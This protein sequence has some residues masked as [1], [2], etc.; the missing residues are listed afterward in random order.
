M[1]G[2]LMHS[3]NLVSSCMALALCVPLSAFADDYRGEVQLTAD[4][5]NPDG[6]AP[7]VDTFTAT[8][9]YYLEPVRTEGLPLAEAAFLGKSSYVSAGAARVD[10][11]G[12]DDADFL[13]AN[14]GYY[15]PNT[16][17]FG[18]LGVAHSEIGNADDTIVN[19]TFGITPFDGLLLTTNFDEDGWDPN[20]SAKYV[21]K[22]ANAHYYAITATAADPD[23]GDTDVGLDFDY[24]L[25]TTFSVG[26]GY[27][28][29]SDSW[30]VRTQK[31]FTPR[32]A[33]GGH[34]TTSDDGDGFGANVTWRF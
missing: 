9:T 15:M 21:G 14:F 23:E 4:R 25:D 33:V 6:D 1:D 22:M 3:R 18:R 5:V 32:F 28:S 17:F 7:H 13:A 8:G 31:F 20:I 26:A 24:F 2:P 12:S 30:S 34:L 16:I 27:G 29:A 10:F 11:G 19:G